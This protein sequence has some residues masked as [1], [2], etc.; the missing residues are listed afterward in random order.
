MVRAGCLNPASYEL[1]ESSFCL[2]ELAGQVVAHVTIAQ[3]ASDIDF[4]S[5][6]HLAC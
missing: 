4:A 2:V 5:Q 6:L 1:L 3:A